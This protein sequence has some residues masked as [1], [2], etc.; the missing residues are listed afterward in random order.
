MFKRERGS[1]GDDW[2]GVRGH[3]EEEEEKEEEANV[4]LSPSVT[5]RWSE[6]E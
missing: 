2:C 4:T 3:K 5:A 6:G 1:R